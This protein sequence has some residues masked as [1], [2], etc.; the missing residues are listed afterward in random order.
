MYM[1]YDIR[2]YVV[3]VSVMELENRPREREKIFRRRGEK[4]RLHVT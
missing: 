2:V 1:D 4:N 3:G